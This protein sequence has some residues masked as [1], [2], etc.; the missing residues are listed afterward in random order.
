[1]VTD[2][3]SSQTSARLWQLMTAA[4]FAL[5]GIWL[6][7][8]FNMMTELQSQIID[9]RKEQASSVREMDE[10]YVPMRELNRI[11]SDNNSRM[12]NIEN[13]LDRLIGIVGNGTN[14]KRD[15]L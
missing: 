10:R 8:Q 5:G 14:H 12:L 7:N 6:Q 9:I 1:M 2:N 4:L 15:D 13:K 11:W 3:I